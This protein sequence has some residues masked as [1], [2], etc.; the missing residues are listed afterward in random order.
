MTTHKN[1]STLVHIPDSSTIG[2]HQTLLK[3][4]AKHRARRADLLIP[5]SRSLPKPISPPASTPSSKDQV[6]EISL[7]SLHVPQAKRAKYEAYYPTYSW[8]E[9]TI[10]NDLPARYALSGEWGGNFIYGA[11]EAERCDEYPRQKKLLHLKKE[12]LDHVSHPP[13]WLSLPLP[14]LSSSPRLPQ[15]SSLNQVLLSSLAPSKFDSIL[16]DPPP[17]L[18]WEE[19]VSLPIRQLSADPSFVFLWVGSGNQDG[20]EKGREALATWGFRRCEEIVW[21]K[22]NRCQ[23]PGS[24]HD[25][26]TSSIFVNTKEHILMG[27]KGTVRRATDGWYV[28]TNVDTDV[29]V[30]EPLQVN[31]STKPP[32]IHTLVENFCMGTRRLDLFG[33]ESQARPGWVVAGFDTPG[34]EKTISAFDRET[35][36][37]AAKIDGK[38]VVPTTAEVENL[39]PKSPTRTNN[40]DKGAPSGTNSQQPWY[41]QSRTGI[42]NAGCIRPIDNTGIIYQPGGTASIGF[43]PDQPMPSNISGLPNM[44]MSPGDHMR[45]DMNMGMP[46]MGLDT[47]IGSSGMNIR[48]NSGSQQGFSH[49]LYLQQQQQ[50]LAFP[51]APFHQSL[52]FNPLYATSLGQGGEKITGP[53]RRSYHKPCL[54]CMSCKKRLDSHLLVEHDEEPY[55]KGCHVKL[56]GT[57]DLRQAN[58]P[59]TTAPSPLSSPIKPASMKTPSISSAPPPFSHSYLPSTQPQPRPPLPST[60]KPTSY[61]SY[62][63]SRTSPVIQQTTETKLETGASLHM[64]SYRREFQPAKERSTASLAVSSQTNSPGMAR[65]EWRV[66]SATDKC[67]GCSKAV[68]FAEQVVALGSKWHKGCLRCFKCS[69]T[70]PPSKVADHEGQVV[71][72]KCHASNFGGGYAIK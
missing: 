48:M 47:A 52:G 54:K 5:S 58:H 55:C 37:T 19:I 22:S 57:R 18:L 6:D 34:I 72:A 62:L 60:P 30:W 29:I 44:A 7:V 12:Q 64:D 53:G 45:M 42:P 38:F 14:K 35:W 1:L 39:R 49:P 69:T 8:E 41:S 43:F 56:F 63:S 26:P 28:H 32:E 68:Y 27:I 59:Y 71:C 2:K 65:R 17:S 15:T 66:E 33:T 21:V 46:G 25:P 10:R 36:E 23:A 9:E 24:G 50:Q 11:D 13:Y 4:V 40:R 16:I 61:T 31:S 20:L 67:A 3:R 51:S 70:L